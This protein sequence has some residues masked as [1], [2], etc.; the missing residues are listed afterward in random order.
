MV[1]WL[2]V[3]LSK[4]LLTKQ[5]CQQQSYAGMLRWMIIF[6]LSI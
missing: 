3:L 5:E 6:N 4:G 1:F 2:S